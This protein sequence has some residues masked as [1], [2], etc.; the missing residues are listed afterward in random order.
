MLFLRRCSF[1]QSSEL[2]E[3]RTSNASWST[4]IPKEPMGFGT[5]AVLEPG[6]CFSAA[7]LQPR[8]VAGN[9]DGSPQLADSALCPRGSLTFPDEQLAMGQ[10][11]CSTRGVSS[12][13]WTPSMEGWWN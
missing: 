7:V 5:E 9:S 11:P 2:C 1:V 8:E 12:S 6:T 13:V 4:R 10:A 3:K